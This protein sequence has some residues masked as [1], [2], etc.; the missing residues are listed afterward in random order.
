MDKSTHRVESKKNWINR[1]MLAEGGLILTNDLAGESVIRRRR[2]Q[3]ENDK[4]RCWNCGQFTIESPGLTVSVA[5]LNL[6]LHL[7]GVG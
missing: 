1:V 4:P 2:T 5:V 7:A 6:T 3:K